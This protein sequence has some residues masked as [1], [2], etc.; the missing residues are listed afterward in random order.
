MLINQLFESVAMRRNSEASDIGK[1]GGIVLAKIEDFFSHEFKVGDA[2][3]I[4]IGKNGVFVAYLE[5]SSIF[6][7]SNRLVVDS[8]GDVYADMQQIDS[9][10]S[11]KFWVEGKEKNHEVIRFTDQLDSLSTSGQ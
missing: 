6:P 11:L 1:Y 8:L 4:D 10:M 5:K 9:N 3:L 2:K 7:K